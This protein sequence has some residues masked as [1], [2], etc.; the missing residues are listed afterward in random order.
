MEETNVIAAIKGGVMRQIPTLQDPNAAIIAKGLMEKAITKMGRMPG[1]DWNR[2]GVTFTFKSGTSVYQCG[3]DLFTAFNRIKNL[4]FIWLT[5]S[6]D[7]PVNVVTLQE[8]N[9]YRRGSTTTGK[10]QIATMHSYNETLEVW[11]IPD[12]AYAEIGR[13][14]V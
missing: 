7:S 1:V 6:Q 12:A 8:F 14:H 3:V 13:A 11:P 9:A 10:P 5:G 4:Q 2:E